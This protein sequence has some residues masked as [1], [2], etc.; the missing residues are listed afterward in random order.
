MKMVLTIISMFIVSVAF[1]QSPAQGQY[2]VQFT[3]KHNSP[4]SINEPEAFLS[5]RSIARRIRQ[6][7]PI[8][9]KDFPVNPAY[10]DTL[11]LKGMVIKH[12]SRWLNAATV[13]ADSSSIANIDSLS[14]VKDIEFVG[15]HL[16]KKPVYFLFNNQDSLFEITL[17]DT[18]YGHAQHQVE[19]LH[20]DRLH[21]LG[22]QGED[23]WIA[24]LDGGFI[25]VDHMPFFDTLRHTGRIQPGMDFVDNDQ[26]VWE[27]SSHG[28]KVL[29]LM[30][31]NIPGFFVGTAPMATYICIKT[32]DTRAEYL[33]EE[34]NWIAGAEYADSIGVDI[35]NSS[36]GYTTF[37][38]DR[39]SY[40]YKDLDGQS[41]KASQAAE[42]A[43][44]KGILVINSAGNSG[45]NSWKYIGIPADSKG[46]LA[47][48]ATDNFGN[49]A[50]FS[51]YGPTAD[52]RLKPNVAAMGEA[53]NVASV[54]STSIQ[55]ADGTSFSAPLIAGMA[56]SLWSAFPH[57]SNKAIFE[58]IERSGHQ[59]GKAD[60]ELGNGIPDF[61]KA[62]LY[63]KE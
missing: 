29:S 55:T 61:Y 34:C 17:L 46:V 59:Y 39:M 58:A 18:P 24:L 38:D 28:S 48:G 1:T 54:Y 25:N 60:Q 16:K 21:A 47:V 35:I 32:E 4:Y 41:S 26:N 49:R 42:I 30:A 22:H 13:I 20:G 33:G 53:V 56:A 11:R 14:F 52:G 62:Y 51:S 3:D 44:Q 40:R 8:D 6:Q 43:F 45:D 27:S 31:S 2:W 37:G 7:I 9:E 36:L 5:A 10:L 63:L 19:M 50:E 15:K 57:K 12:T 23:I